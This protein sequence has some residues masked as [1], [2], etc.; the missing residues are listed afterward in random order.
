MIHD[1]SFACHMMWPTG[2]PR[3]PRRVRAGGGVT[4]TAMYCD[5][6]SIA[7]M[8]IGALIQK[9][10]E[11]FERKFST[12]SAMHLNSALVANHLRCHLL[13]SAP[14]GASES[15][16]GQAM[17]MVQSHATCKQFKPR[18][19]IRNPRTY[20]TH[21]NGYQRPGLSSLLLSPSAI[22]ERAAHHALPRT[23][24]LIPFSKGGT[25]KFISKSS[26]C[27]IAEALRWR[28]EKQASSQSR[29]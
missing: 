5:M 25:Q 11:I 23:Q 28:A 2:A 6:M 22:L 24:C 14:R 13:T 3:A 27:T 15:I 9:L 19:E 4:M 16:N 17:S 8:S 29:L 20:Q 1:Y 21:G 18:L 26:Y 12:F 10:P 7:D